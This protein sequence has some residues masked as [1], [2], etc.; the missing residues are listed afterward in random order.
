MQY[1]VLSPSLTGTSIN[2]QV[3]LGFAQNL[4]VQSVDNS[5][6]TRLTGYVIFQRLFATWR[7]TTWMKRF[8]LIVVSETMLLERSS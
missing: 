6:V 8:A 2:V 4:P 3:G 5:R 1:N 7:C